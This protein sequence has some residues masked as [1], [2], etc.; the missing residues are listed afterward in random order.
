MDDRHHIH[1]FDLC[2]ARVGVVAR[3]IARANSRRGVHLAF[4]FGFYP[5]HWRRRCVGVD[6]G[7]NC[8]WHSHAISAH[9]CGRRWIYAATQLAS[10][11]DRACCDRHHVDGVVGE[12]KLISISLASIQVL[13]CVDLSQI[14][15]SAFVSAQAPRS[16]AH[17]KQ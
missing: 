5:R 10:C 8:V 14:R 15:A 16:D 7:W 6:D 12:I 17:A 1:H 13:A 3:I 9:H 11:V 4:T 2:W